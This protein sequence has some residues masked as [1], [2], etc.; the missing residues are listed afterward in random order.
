MDRNTAGDAAENIRALATLIATTKA[1]FAGNRTGDLVQAG[2]IRG[3]IA[4]HGDDRYAA[5]KIEK[6][7]TGS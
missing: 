5:I 1:A 3:R 4:N 7:A 6:Q 2:D